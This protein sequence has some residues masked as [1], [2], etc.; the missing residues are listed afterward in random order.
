M[1]YHEA[2]KTLSLVAGENLN[3]DQYKL[4]SINASGL[5]I[6]APALTSLIVGVLAENPDLNDVGDDSTGRIVPIYSLQG[7]IKAKALGVVTAGR[8]VIWGTGGLVTEGTAATVAGIPAT[9]MAVGVFLESGVANQIVSFL[10]QPM[11]TF[12]T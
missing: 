4:I 8:P 12:G 10:A 7:I 2:I 3:D 5:A 1:A 9:S 11:T 6:V